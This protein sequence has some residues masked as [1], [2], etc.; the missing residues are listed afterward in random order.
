MESILVYDI[1]IFKWS[2]CRLWL[3]YERLC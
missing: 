3:S 2:T 1:Y